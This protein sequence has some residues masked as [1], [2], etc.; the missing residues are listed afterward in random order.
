[1]M[2]ELLCLTSVCFV[3]S[4]RQSAI[5]LLFSMPAFNTFLFVVFGASQGKYEEAELLAKRSLAMVEKVYGHDHPKVVIDLN[6]YATL[7]SEQ[8]RVIRSFLACLLGVKVCP[9]SF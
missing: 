1:M 8:V 6:N 4:A 7:L 3:V 9:R 5:V 2:G